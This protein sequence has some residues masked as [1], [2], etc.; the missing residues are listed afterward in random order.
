MALFIANVGAHAQIVFTSHRDG[1]KE[2]Y[3]MGV[4]GGN[5]RNLI[6]ITNLNITHNPVE[7]GNG[8]N[9]V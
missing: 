9:D 6:P 1:N 8:L 4:D 2:I 5:P 7:T 3:V